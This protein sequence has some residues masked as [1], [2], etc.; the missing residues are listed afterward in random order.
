[1][2]HRLSHGAGSVLVLACVAFGGCGG[3]SMPLALRDPST[4]G[5]EALRQ[6]IRSALLSHDYRGQCELFTPVL[7]QNYGGTIASCANSMKAAES[8]PLATYGPYNTSPSVYVA[9]GT[10]AMAGNVAAYHNGEIIFTAVY[11]EGMWKV[12][13]NEQQGGW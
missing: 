9:G 5:V 4:Q 2:R 13:A 8:L 7:L 11:T 1:M 12:V 6:A 3:T 10:I